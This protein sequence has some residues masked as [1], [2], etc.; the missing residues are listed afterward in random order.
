M[1]VHPPRFRIGDLVEHLH[2][3]LSL[4][5]VVALEPGQPHGPT[6][7]LSETW[8]SYLVHWSVQP[9]PTLTLEE[10]NANWFKEYHLAAY[11]DREAYE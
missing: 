5:L 6:G 9:W 3:P 11:K 8:S 1:S 7:D 4:G 10:N 2:R